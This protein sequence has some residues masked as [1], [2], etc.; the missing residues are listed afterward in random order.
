MLRNARMRMQENQQRRDNIFG[1]SNSKMNI[2]LINY[3][4]NIVH[5]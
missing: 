5:E 3:K 4:S 2:I 1:Q